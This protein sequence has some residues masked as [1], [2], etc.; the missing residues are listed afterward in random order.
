MYVRVLGVHVRNIQ[1][2]PWENPLEA[3]FLTFCFYRLR[4]VGLGYVGF[5]LALRLLGFR[6][7]M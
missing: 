2:T 7:R 1:H 3:S 4:G 6:V 5:F